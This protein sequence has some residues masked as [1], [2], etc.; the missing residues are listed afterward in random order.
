MFLIFFFCNFAFFSSFFSSNFLK[1]LLKVS[2]VATEHQKWPR[3]DKNRIKIQKEKKGL[4]KGQ[5]PLQELE[6]SWRS[7]L[8]RLVFTIMVVIIY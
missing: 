4:A 8:Y 2:E 1:F 7:G 5:S 3:I 6:E